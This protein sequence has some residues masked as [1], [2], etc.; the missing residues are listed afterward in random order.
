MMNV[1]ME[2]TVKKE[3]A[4]ETAKISMAKKYTDS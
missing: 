3:S 2:N 4:R 1:V